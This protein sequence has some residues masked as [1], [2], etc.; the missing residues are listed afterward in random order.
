MNKQDQQIAE[1]NA[2]VKTYIAPSKI[3]GVGVFALRDIAKGQT[4]G[5]DDLFRV[6]TLPYSSFK[7]LFPEVRKLL[8]GR[9]PQ[10]VNGSHFMYPTDRSQAYMNH[11]DTPNYCGFKD[12]ALKD[13]KKDEEVTEDYKLIPNHVVVYPWL[14]DK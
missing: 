13:I 1:L 14:K 9:W 10:V 6:Y 7:K 4:L 3:H 5:L 12:A 11:S 2:A 8:L